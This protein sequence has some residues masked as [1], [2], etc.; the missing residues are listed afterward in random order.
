[1]RKLAGVLA[2][3]CLAVASPASATNGMRMPGFGPV[4][5]SMGGVGVGATL[6]SAALVSNPAG[7]ADLD[8]RI[9]VSLTLFMPKVSYDATGI[10]PPLVANPGVTIDSDRGPSPIPFVGGVMTLAPGLKL[11]LGVTGVAGM[12]V[13]YKTNLYSSPT[14]TSYLQGRFAPAIGWRVNDLL[15]VGLTLNGMVAQMKYDV[16]SQFGQ[17][18]H[19]TATALGIGATLGV[20]VTPVKM[21]AIGAA[22]ETKS[23][24]K[25]FSFDIPAHNTPF[26]AVPGGTDKLTF[27]QPQVVTL[28]VS[29]APGDALVVAADVQW[30]NWAQTNGKNLPAYSNDTNLTGAMPFDLDWKNQ[31]VLKIGAQ[32]AATRELRIRAGWNYGKNPLNPDR[33]FESIAFPAIAEHHISLGLGYSFGQLAVNV[34]GTYA[35]KVSQSGSNPLPPPGTPG[36][37]GPYGQGI[38]SYT[39]SMSQIA[40]DAGVAYRF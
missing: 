2:V 11:G 6:D 29:V 4:Q 16:A 39:T 28:G 26:G 14:L 38:Q 37:P 17:V 21:V 8:P 10:A 24:F 1:M 19:D 9:D 32:Y 18:P 5:N 36:Y 3:L 12:G 20:K 13:D 25:D 23:F 35:P 27:H 7:L 30:I 40:I 15:A 31:L 33:A 34:G 22:W